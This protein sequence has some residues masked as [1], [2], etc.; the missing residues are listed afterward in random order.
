M[1]KAII[2]ALALIIAPA[3]S[4]AQEEASASAALGFVQ[5]GKDAAVDGMG[6]AGLTSTSSIAWSSYTNAAAIP[7][8]SQKGDIA[9]SYQLWQPTSTHYI[10]LGGGFNVKEKIGIAFGVTMGADGAYTGVSDSGQ[11]LKSFKPMDFQGNFGISY[12]FVPWVSIGVNAR[13]AMEKVAD[14]YTLGSFMADAFVMGKYQDFSATLGAVNLGTKA[15]YGKKS[16]VDTKYPIPAAVALGL[17]YTP[18]FAEKHGIAINADMRYS[19]SGLGFGAAFGAAYTYNDMVSVRG[20]YCYG[21][22]AIASH[23]SLGLGVK[24]AGVHIDAAYYIAGKGNPIAN[25]VS[26]GLGYSF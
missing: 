12:R 11:E 8:S 5:F 18:V 9:F 20:G 2:F 13:Y 14:G 25:T 16:G 3:M 6:G 21:G 22:K 15:S 24:F 26:V 7:F 4:F 19:L 1:K 17:G 10:N 23:A